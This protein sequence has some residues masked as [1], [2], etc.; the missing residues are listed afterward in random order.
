MK[1][2]LNSINTKQILAEALISIASKKTLSKITV[3]ELVDYCDINRKTFYYHFTDIYD[4]LEWTLNN[5]IEQVISNYNPI[6]DIN[7]TISYSVNYINRHPHLKNILKDA[8]AREKITQL[9]NKAISPKS[10]EL[11]EMLEHT[12]QQ[13]METD[14]KQ[15]LAKSLTH[16]IILSLLDS[17]ENPNSYDIE[18]LQQYITTLFQMSTNTIL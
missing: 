16:I 11:I 3:S 7:A 5:E 2:K 14:F 6:N 15:F 10:L 9:L 8:I 12:K 18:K 1:H 17:I 4:L 13:P